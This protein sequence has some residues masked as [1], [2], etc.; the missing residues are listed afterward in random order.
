[1]HHRA[2]WGVAAGGHRSGCVTREWRM[3]FS[4]RTANAVIPIAIAVCAVNCSPPTPSAPSVPIAQSPDSATPAPTTYALSGDARQYLAYV[5][6]NTLKGA[7]F[8]NEEGRKY[9]ELQHAGLVYAALRADGL[10]L[11]HAWAS[12]GSVDAS[13]ARAMAIALADVPPVAAPGIDAVEICVSHDYRQVGPRIAPMP[14]ADDTGV[15]GIEVRIDNNLLRRAPTAMLA[16]N[17]TFESVI[18]HAKSEWDPNATKDT[19]IFV[20]DC[21]QLLVDVGSVSSLPMYRG[22]S[23]VP[24]LSVTPSAARALA[25]GM[26]AWL[27]NNSREDGSLVY[28]YSPSRRQD[29]AANNTIRQFLAT[30]ALERW[31][32]FSG[33]AQAVELAKRNLKHNLEVFCHVEEDLGIVSDEDGVK[34]GAIALAA[35]AI[36]EADRRAE[37]AE[38]LDALLQTV[39]RLWNS[40]TGRF[41]TYLR[42]QGVDENQNFYPGEALLLWSVLYDHDR[43]ATLLAK[44]M[45]SFAYYRDWHRADRNPAFVPWHTQA[46]C[47]VWLH[48]HDDALRDFVF[49]MN[50]WLIST[51]QWDDAPYPDMKG[52]F[53]SKSVPNYGPPH[54][55]STGVYLEGLAA[56]Y[57]MAAE[58]K[59]GP[60]A[61]RYREA[62]TRGLRNIMQLQFADDLD[63]FYVG[64]DERS[65]VRGGIRTTEY[66]NTIRVDNVAH[67]LLAVTTLL[68]QAPAALAGRP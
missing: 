48:T 20:F 62:I 63:A 67:N 21:E 31:A 46:Y 64:S 34:L 44:I 19:G 61:D 30:L 49:E 51:Q 32:R 43:D 40:G 9:L 6:A 33:D 13:L 59:D 27:V 65:R 11:A 17:E 2:F 25:D 56:A 50:D 5:A 1:M 4:M 39:D 29:D 23:L 57:R 47:N 55:S 14:T 52:R 66:N 42:P 37:Y 36:I 53:F 60:R 7:G 26:A 18:E 22:N 10:E 3:K 28:R 45:K 16:A 15:L 24:I 8:A 41:Q 35:L 68:S 12:L 54:A 58:D 38:L